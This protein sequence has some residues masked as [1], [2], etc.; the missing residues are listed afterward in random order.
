[1][2]L[3]RFEPTME[4]PIEF[5]DSI[6]GRALLAAT[7]AIAIAFAALY[8]SAV[9]PYWK[10]TPDSTTY[11]LGAQSLANGN[12]YREAGSPA[13]LFPPGTSA[14]LAAAWIAGGKSYRALNAEVILFAFASLAI[15][16]LL[17]RDSLGALGS[18]V[19]VLLC[20][21]STEFFESSTFVLSEIFFVF[22]SLLALWWYQRDS[23]IGAVLS[24]LA[25]C[26]VRSVG[27]SLAAALL[28]DSLLKRPRRWTRAASYT[29]PLLFAVFWELRNRRLGWSYTELMTENEPWARASGHIT[30]G[31]IISRFAGNFAYGRALEDLLTNGLTQNI[32]WAILPGIF[33]ATLIAVGFWRLSRNGK[34]T[35]GKS[36]TGI[37]FILFSITV[38]LY[39]P[40]VVVRLFVPLLPLMFAYLVAGVQEVAERRSL[41]WVYAVAALFVGLYLVTGFREDIPLVADERRSPFPNEHV[42]YAGYYD[43]QRL[44]LWWKEHAAEGDI[45]ACEHPNVIGIITGRAGVT[46]VVTSQPAALENSL[47]STHARFLLLNLSS[48]SDQALALVA[49]RSAKFRLTRQEGRARLYE[50]ADWPSR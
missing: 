32:G 42:K 47:R 4:S 14:L 34:S 29:L 20:L 45:Y 50:L 15:C 44:A 23:T 8:C 36:A 31:R 2:L 40:S 41:R 35:N 17:F 13:V 48:G 16:F 33:L 39:W 12:G 7:I 6:A 3:K 18:G 28:L 38:A 26:L 30:V 37:Y 43:M 11:V 21:G 24:A 10:L 19:V 9:S 5:K 1:M 46:S 22:F 49:E 25:A 27:V